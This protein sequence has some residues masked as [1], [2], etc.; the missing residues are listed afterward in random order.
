MGLMLASLERAAHLVGAHIEHAA[1]DHG[2]TQAE[3]HVLVRLARDGSTS[4][5][6]LH[7]EF[8]TKR[9]TLTNVLDRLEVRQLIRRELNPNDRRSFTVHLTRRGSAPAR[10]LARVMDELDA[11]IRKTT[12]ARDVQGVHAVVEA[13]AK[14]NELE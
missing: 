9:S 3:A 7:R 12:S 2:I 10:D 11:R 4:I 8:G 6:T 5:A 13:L 1:R 14:L